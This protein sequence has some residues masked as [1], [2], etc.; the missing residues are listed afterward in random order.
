MTYLHIRLSFQAQNVTHV[1]CYY[2]VLRSLTTKNPW[3]YQTFFAFQ[4]KKTP[5]YPV[6]E[7]KQLGK[8]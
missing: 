7:L 5:E 6:D 2:K 1:D 4:T 8:N 3:R